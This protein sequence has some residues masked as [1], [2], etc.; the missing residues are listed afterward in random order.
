METLDIFE[1]VSYAKNNPLSFIRYCEII[2]S[3][4]GKVIIIDPSHTETA[5]KYAMEK[6]HCT[7]QDIIDEMPTTCYPIEWLVDKYNLVAVWYSGYMYCSKFNRFQKRSINI[8]IKNGLIDKASELY[9]R[10]A[11]AYHNYIKGKII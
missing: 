2:L 6:D 5:I 10:E 4:H 11:T 8:L 1:F 9:I 3:P 7:R